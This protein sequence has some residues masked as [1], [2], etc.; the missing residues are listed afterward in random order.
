MGGKNSKNADIGAFNN[1]EDSISVRVKKD[2]K[3]NE[4]KTG[5]TGGF[6]PRKPLEVPNKEEK[7]EA[8]TK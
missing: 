1:L 2:K 7:E 6:V 4:K 3:A 8:E 5:T